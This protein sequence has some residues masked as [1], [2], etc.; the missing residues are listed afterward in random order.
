ML[1]AGII[2]RTNDSDLYPSAEKDPYSDG[3]VAIVIAFCNLMVLVIFV[4]SLLTFTS[5]KDQ[6]IEDKLAQ[7]IVDAAA[8]EVLDAEVWHIIIAKGEAKLREL[9]RPD[10]PAI[11]LLHSTA[12]IIKRDEWCGDYVGAAGKKKLIC[13]L[14]VRG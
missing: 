6:S 11:N 13:D 14:K 5:K 7:K 3:V 10:H 4:Y 12:N 8:E 2:L 9:M 1:H